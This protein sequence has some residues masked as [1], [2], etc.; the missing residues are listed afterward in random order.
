[1][2]FFVLPFRLLLFNKFYSLDTTSCGSPPHGSFSSAACEICFPPY[3][4]FSPTLFRSPSAPVPSRKSLFVIAPDSNPVRSYVRR[5][6]HQSCSL[7]IFHPPFGEMRLTSLP[8]LRAPPSVVTRCP[9]FLLS[10][11]SRS[12]IH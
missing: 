8:Q 4:S 11:R 9:S 5:L 3:S 2:I 1:M 10:H 12:V 6:I 7:Y